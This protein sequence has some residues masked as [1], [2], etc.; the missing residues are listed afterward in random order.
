LLGSFAGT[1]NRYEVYVLTKQ[2]SQDFLLLR[3][4]RD[5]RQV[6]EPASLALAF[7]ALGLLGAAR[8]KRRSA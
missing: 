2:G 3:D 5:D 6:P 7:G 4:K 8:R 1:A